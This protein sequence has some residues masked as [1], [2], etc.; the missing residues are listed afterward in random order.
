MKKSKG[1]VRQGKERGDEG[2]KAVM[3]E[4]EKVEG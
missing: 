4:R 1:R 2:R 3:E